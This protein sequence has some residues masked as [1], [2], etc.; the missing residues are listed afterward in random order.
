VDSLKSDVA[1]LKNHVNSLRSDVNTLKSDVSSLK[2]D[3][4]YLRERV[5]R[6]EGIM[7]TMRWSIWLGFTLL[8]LLVSLLR[9]L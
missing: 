8:A 1:L 3:V 4:I 2:N 6:V 9:V 5:A 7:E